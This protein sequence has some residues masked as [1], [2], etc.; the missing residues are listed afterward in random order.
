MQVFVIAHSGYQRDALCSLLS[1]IFPAYRF[2]GLSEQSA[3]DELG[4][5]FNMDQGLVISTQALPLLDKYLR[6]SQMDHLIISP[7]ASTET[8]TSSL[9]QILPTSGELIS[10]A[11]QMFSAAQCD[12]VSAEYRLTPKQLKVLALLIE[13]DASKHIAKKL[14]LS[15]STIKTHIAAIFRAFRVRTRMELLLVTEREG[16]RLI[17]SQHSLMQTRTYQ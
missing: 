8:L 1:S 14:N 10:S 9:R 5:N 4:G 6:G 15:P 7:H 13:G 3:L 12:P 17:A 11:T 2:R 16:L